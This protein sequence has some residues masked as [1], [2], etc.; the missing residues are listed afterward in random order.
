MPKAIADPE[1]LEQFARELQVFST[2]L[3]DRMSHLKGR[4]SALG[5]TWQDQ[6]EA[7]FA[8]EFEQTMRVLDQFLRTANHQV[9]FLRRKAQRLREYLGQ[10]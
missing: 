2:T 10:R 6:E 9:P 3:K 5:Q 1:D 8:R 7:K 4:Y